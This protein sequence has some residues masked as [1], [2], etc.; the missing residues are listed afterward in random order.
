MKRT[1]LLSSLSIFV[2][3]AAVLMQAQGSWSFKGTV[4]NM[5][6]TEC[7][8]QHGF[9][10]AMSGVPAP[11]TVSCPE[12]TIMSDKVVYV[13]EGRQ[14]DAFMPLAQNME[15]LVRKNE[16]VTFSDD[17]KNKSH[18][19]IQQMTLRSEWDREEARKDMD[20]KAERHVNYETRN[21]PRASMMM[22][23]SSR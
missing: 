1:T 8:A 7:T 4:V 15:F 20:A 13:V 23:A 17:E 16:L 10:A 6:M 19:G 5:R 22:P 12:Y 9:L 21:P 11:A 14:K 18:F 3:S 2:F